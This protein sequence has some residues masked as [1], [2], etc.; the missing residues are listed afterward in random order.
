VT[1]VT[2][3]DLAL[4]AAKRASKGAA[5]SEAVDVIVQPEGQLGSLEVA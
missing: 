3:I 1:Q 2:S 4:S 5:E